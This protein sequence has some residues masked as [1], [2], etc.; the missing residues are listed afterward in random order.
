MTDTGRGT[1]L[2]T[3]R[4]VTDPE[5]LTQLTIAPHETAIEVPMV[6]RG[7]YGATPAQ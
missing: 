2:I 4:P 6:E 7:F 1:F 3:G 5:T